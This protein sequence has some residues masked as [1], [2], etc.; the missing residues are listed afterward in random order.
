MS[1]VTHDSLPLPETSLKKTAFQRAVLGCVLL[2]TVCIGLVFPFPMKGR[3]W[4]E[5]FD[6]AH[7]PVFFVS[8]VCLIGFFD[9]S[10][11][12]LP[13]RLVT[14]ISMTFGRVL[15]VTV[16]L[17]LIGLVG[18]FLQRFAGRNPSWADV[19]ANSTGLIAG[20][21]WIASVAEQGIKRFFLRLGVVV[22][23]VA[24]STPS[25][26]EAWASIQQ[27]RNFPRLASFERTRELGSWHRHRSSIQ[28]SNDWSSDGHYSAKVTLNPADY[29]GASMVWFEQDWTA[30]RTLKLDLHNPAET[31]LHLVIKLYDQQHVANGFEFDD[32]FH[33]SV[34]LEPKSSANV[35]IDLVDVQSAPKSRQIHLDRMAAIDI[36][37]IDVQQPTNFFVDHLR[38]EK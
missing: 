36:F 10:A 25:A 37:S 21:L 18:E 38:L 14:L 3:L 27:I 33:R 17:M 13:K 28:R 24:V 32:R 8:L 30:F 2:G 34:V 22:A 35:T 23:L 29:P 6:L 4:G 11:V 15:A 26:L 31:E 5:I 7:A 20:L 12:G 19:A 9:P 1:D 16:A